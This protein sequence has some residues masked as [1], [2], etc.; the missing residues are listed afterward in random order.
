MTHR[1]LLAL[2]TLMITQTVRAGDDPAVASE[3]DRESP[4]RQATFTVA[5]VYR[6]ASEA[7]RQ[8]KTIQVTYDVAQTKLL[9]LPAFGGH[10]LSC[11][12]RK[13]FVDLGDGRRMLEQNGPE[14]I[15]YSKATFNGEKSFI[16]APGGG[17]VAVFDGKFSKYLDDSEDYCPAFLNMPIHDAAIVQRELSWEYPHCLRSFGTSQPFVM[18][19]TLEQINGRWCHVLESKGMHILWVDATIGCAIVQRYWLDGVLDRPQLT[20]LLSCDKF[21]NVGGNLWV[22][23]SGYW[24]LFS[25]PNSPPEFL[26]KPYYRTTLKVA[27]VAINK[28]TENDIKL[29]IKPG[30][31]IQ[32]DG[33]LYKAEGASAEILNELIQRGPPDKSSRGWIALLTWTTFL[34]LVIAGLIVAKA[35]YTR[36]RRSHKTVEDAR[37]P[38][39]TP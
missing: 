9:D 16:L 21:A 39:A 19:P 20:K 31:L 34:L 27:N 24:E 12:A 5:D 33:K 6:I 26:G 36:W 3:R 37:L 8:I 28:A 17:T 30:M 7:K 4:A 23:V 35:L 29:D 15:G 14:P 2:C 18:R 13:T 32:E 25:P 10:L 38:E 1:I 11:S 22:P